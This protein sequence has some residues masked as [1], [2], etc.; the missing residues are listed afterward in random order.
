MNGKIGL[1]CG[2]PLL[3]GEQKHKTIQGQRTVRRGKNRTAK[4]MYRLRSDDR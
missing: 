2:F 3:S 4:K 1:K